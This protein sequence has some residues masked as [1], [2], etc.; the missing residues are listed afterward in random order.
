MSEAR[1]QLNFVPSADPKGKQVRDSL[2]AVEVM[3]DGRTLFTASDE[4]IGELPCLE[5]LTRDAEGNYGQHE[6]LPLTDFIELPEPPKK[7]GRPPEV[8]L[9]GLSYH[10][11]YLWVVG[12]Y[13]AV[14]QK[15]KSRD[16]DGILELSKIEDGPNRA[17]LGRIPVLAAENGSR[18]CPKDGQRRAAVLKSDLRKVLRHDPLL[19]PFLWPFKNHEGESVLLPGKDNGFDIEGIAAFGTS[20][21]RT[22]L[23]LGLRGPVLRGYAILIELS[24]RER[25]GGRRLE[26]EEFPDGQ[27][28]R[29]H[30]LPLDG[31]GVRDLSVRG[32]DLWILAG[33]TMTLSAPV[34]LYKYAGFVDS[35]GTETLAPKRPDEL[36]RVAQFPPEVG[37]DNAE[38]MTF[39]N[40]TTEGDDQLLIVYDSPHSDRL[41]DPATTLGDVV[42]ISPDRVEQA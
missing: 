18:L 11:G 2:S 23:F 27:R 29:R 33:P 6:R 21:K 16:A 40:P 7:K 8:D 22:R 14:R 15:P 41:L 19:G 20:A 25:S 1:I 10:Q 4:T 39:L 30:L 42:V 12:S 3:D 17:I 38:G 34:G 13:S 31:L 26:L 32:S 35:V 37:V 24:V 28:Y 5:R 9:E 36:K